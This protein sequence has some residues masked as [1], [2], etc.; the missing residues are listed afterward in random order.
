MAAAKPVGFVA[1]GNFQQRKNSD[2]R[3]I[4]RLLD[5]TEFH[6][7][8]GVAVTVVRAAV[9]RRVV[10]Q[11]R[12]EMKLHVGDDAVVQLKMRRGSRPAVR[13]F[14]VL[15]GDVKFPMLIIHRLRVVRQKRRAGPILSVKSQSD[16][17]AI[18]TDSFFAMVFPFLMPQ[19][20]QS[21][22]K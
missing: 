9:G 5:K 3:Q 13:S 10:S 20:F 21:P 11:R 22:I 1:G 16:I 19:E 15:R 2:L 18:A 14:G 7:E 17:T 6:A 4:F 12:D 8:F